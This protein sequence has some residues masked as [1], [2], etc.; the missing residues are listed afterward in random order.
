MSLAEA[1][2]AVLAEVYENERLYVGHLPGDPPTWSDVTRKFQR[3]KEDVQLP[4]GWVWKGDWEVD[5]EQ[6]RLASFFFYPQVGP[7]GPLELAFL[8]P[9]SS[10]L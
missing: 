10:P 8:T 2:K 1:D 4:P 5:P 9:S 7:S 6:V 3:R